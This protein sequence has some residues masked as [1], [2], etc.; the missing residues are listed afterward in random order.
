MGD[1]GNGWRY[2]IA[3]DGY[4]KDFDPKKRYK[5]K[6]DYQDE[7]SVFRLDDCSPHFNVGGGSY[8]SRAGGRVMAIDWSAPLELLDG[9][10]VRLVTIYEMSGLY[11]GTNPDRDGHYW[12]KRE[13]GK[14]IDNLS[15]ICIDSNAGKGGDSPP[16]VRNREG[17]RLA[18]SLDEARAFLGEEVE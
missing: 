11:G 9:T 12:I 8:V 6:R 7:A 4:H 18:D 14:Y 15:K 5:F 13:D 10:P 17:H 1:A 16:I 3:G 2:V